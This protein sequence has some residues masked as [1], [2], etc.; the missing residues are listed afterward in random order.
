MEH[1][2]NTSQSTNGLPYT[3][4]GMTG[5]KHNIIPEYHS[6]EIVKFN[7]GDIVKVYDKNGNVIEKYI[8]E[9]DTLTGLK[10]WKKQ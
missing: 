8:I 7:E 6:T 3:N 10:I 1:P 9:N 2:F 5:S 4:T